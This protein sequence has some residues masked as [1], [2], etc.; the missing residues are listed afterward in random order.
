LLLFITV[1]KEHWLIDKSLDYAVLVI[2]LLA[3]QTTT[4]QQTNEYIRNRERR[5]SPTSAAARRHSNGSERYL[6]S[7]YNFFGI[8]AGY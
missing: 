4:I 1:E 5:K 3:F 7:S 6:P 8:T 2:I